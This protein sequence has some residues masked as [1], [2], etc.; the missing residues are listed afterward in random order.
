MRKRKQT[1]TRWTCRYLAGRPLDGYPRTDS[2]FWERGTKALTETGRASRWA[3]LPGY[4]RAAIRIAVPVGTVT[5]S[6]GYAVAPETAATMTA[7]AALGTGYL[8]GRKALRYVRTRTHT[9][10]VVKPL[11]AALAPF[12]DLPADQL[13]ERLI[14]PEPGADLAEAE[15]RVPLADHHAGRTEQVKD[16]TRV[17]SQRIGGEWNTA[18]NLRTAPFYLHF[19]PRPAPPGE[20]P[21]AMVRDAVLATSQDRPVLGLGT[22]C[23]PIHLDFTGEIAHLAASI[24]TGGGK[25]SL[26]RFLVAQFAHHGVRDFDVCD[27]KWVSLAGMED[28]PGLNIYRDVEDIWDAIALA[29]AEMD[30]RYV[31]LL[32]DPR[33]TFPRKV[34]ILEE[35]N[36]FALETAIRWREVRG[37]DK[38]NTAPVWNDVALLLVKA[39]QVNINLIGVYQRMTADSCGGGTLRDQY[40]LK[41]LSRF[42]PQAWDTLVGTKPR[43]VSSA[44]PGRAIAVLGGLHRAVQLPFITVEDAMELATSGPA[45]TVTH[46]T[47]PQVIHVSQPVVTPQAPRYTLAEIDREKLCTVTY[48]SLRQHVTRARKA[49]RLETRDDKTYTLDELAAAGVP[50]RITTNGESA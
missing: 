19:T 42:S 14:L 21:Y 30:R 39:R 47:S 26:L 50:V 44:I 3:M 37:K 43:G 6:I 48:G 49:G 17:V 4:E 10:R 25:S 29:R 22:G 46:G 40:G 32:K 41:L 12:T 31:E 9:A 8:A 11:A 38:R 28:V 34:I 27:V 36:A 15:I 24:G 23:E 16:I 20:V 18:L 5:G 1:L 7:A 33:R 35:Q 2:T 13:R 45:V